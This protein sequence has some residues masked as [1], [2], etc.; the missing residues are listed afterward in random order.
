M[1]RI[2]CWMR[3]PCD[4]A[5]ALQRPFPDSALKIVM[6]GSDKEDHGA[7]GE[8][9]MNASRRWAVA[10]TSDDDIDLKIARALFKIGEPK[11]GEITVFTGRVATALF[12]DQFDTMTD[13]S[14][15]ADASSPIIDAING[16]CFIHDAARSP[17][18]RGGIH[19]RL[20]NGDWGGG[21]AFAIG[22]MR[23]RSRAVAFGAALDKD[24]N[25]LANPQ[26][27]QSVWLQNAVK[28]ENVRDAL[29]YLRGTPD[30]FLLYKAYETMKKDGGPAVWPDTERFSRS[31]NIH[32]HF[33]G[34]PSAK[35]TPNKPFVPM[36]LNEAT[37]FIRSLA[38]T[39]L[40]SK[41]SSR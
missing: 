21:T 23:G 34:H 39:W 3:S 30:W 19:E 15:V 2:G 28:D 9:L 13:A 41:V 11:V 14:V 20:S 27:Q 33:S 18:R 10:L 16:I 8:Y 22:E 32:R 6:R 37:S 31:A 24:G 26:S 12:S 38:T 7:H 1:N 4:E 40:N 36:D 29:A 35:Q 17:L 5:K 25:V